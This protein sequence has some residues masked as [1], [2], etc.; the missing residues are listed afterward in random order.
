MDHESLKL[1]VDTTLTAIYGPERG[2]KGT[3]EK[4]RNKIPEDFPDSLALK[5]RSM[6][7]N[8]R[9]SEKGAKV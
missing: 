5:S 3:K 2:E 4:F 7:R 8:R 9:G 6:D 1:R